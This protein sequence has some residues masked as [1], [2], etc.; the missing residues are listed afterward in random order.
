M[1]LGLPRLE[2]VEMVLGL[3]L[4]SNWNPKVHPRHPQVHPGL[5]NPM[6]HSHRLGTGWLH[7]D[8]RLE[9]L[10]CL[11]PCLDT[12]LL[13]LAL[14]TQDHREW[15]L[16]QRKGQGSVIWDHLLTETIRH[17]QMKMLHWVR[18]QELV[19]K[20]GH[21]PYWHQ[22]R[23]EQLRQNRSKEGFQHQLRYQT[24]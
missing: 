17:C 22:C 11:R 16:V 1:R 6:H 4:G 3:D 2:Q 5:R 9:V 12:R 10:E 8:H 21:P 18:V 15:E 24:R 23:W 7:L 14:S 20:V 13:V 19:T